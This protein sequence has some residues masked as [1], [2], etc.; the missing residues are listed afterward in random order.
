MRSKP[1]ASAIGKSL[2]AAGILASA[3][4]ALAAVELGPKKLECAF[5]EPFFS[6]TLDLDKGELTKTAIDWEDPGNKTITTVVGS[7]L[8]ISVAPYEK[9]IRVQAKTKAGKTLL[10][11]TLKY[12]GSDG[13]SDATMPYDAEYSEVAYAHKLYGGCV[14][15]TGGEHLDPPVDH[16]YYAFVQNVGKAVGLCYNRALAEWTDAPSDYK[17]EQ[18]VFYT[19]YA[20][21]IPAGEPGDVSSTFASAE[22]EKL[23]ELVDLTKTP[24]EDGAS[25]NALRKAKWDY[26][27][28][29]SGRLNSRLENLKT[30]E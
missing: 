10:T 20:R 15:E 27:D 16:Q 26:C 14:S 1:K 13:M 5:T 11:S 12:A 8:K 24:P 30:Q 19:L 7:D 25:L 2:L 28:Y 23:G 4:P 17:P 6:L 18:S 9:T 3:S 29:Y 22:N 21:E